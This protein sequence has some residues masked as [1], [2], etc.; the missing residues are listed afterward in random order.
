MSTQTPSDSQYRFSKT[1]R[2]L[3]A[4]VG[5]PNVGKSSLFNRLVGRREAIVSDIAGTTRDRISVEVN[6]GDT[7]FLIVDTGGLM[8]D[9]E[10]EMELE[11]TSQVDSAITEADVVVFMTDINLGVTPADQYVADQLRRSKQ[12]VILVANKA[13][14]PRLEAMLPDQYKLGLGDPIAISAYHNIGVDDMLSSILDRLPAYTPLEEF[15]DDLPRIAIVGR[16]NVGKSALTNAFLGNE[17]SIVNGIPGTTRDSLDSSMY[18]QGQELRFVDTAGVRRRG[19]INQGIERYSVLR[20]IR[21]IDRSDVA[22]LVLDATELVTAQ[23]LHVAG[24]VAQD[25]K[26]VV[27]AVNKW[28]LS[29]ENE[30]DQADIREDVRYRLKFIPHAPVRFVSALTKEGIEDL[31]DAALEVYRQRQKWIDHVALQRAMM[32]AIA[33]HLPPK[34]GRGSMKI[35]RVKQESTS[36]PTF[37]FYCNNPHLMHFSYERYLENVLRENFGFQGTHLRLEFRGKGK[38][39][40]AG[41][42]RMGAKIRDKSK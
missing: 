40:I 19:S 2:P 33:K 30:L 24:I 7:T 15:E 1:G 39:H 3:V 29:R 6:Y 13:D 27:L 35:Y 41:E 21:A 18:Y 20:T 28:D 14:N 37:V 16:P 17:R 22:I 36:P 23:D 8:I 5:R 32:Y 26:G 11:I 38:I 25:F 4:I 9:P 42:H 10:S 12:P 34:H 31:L